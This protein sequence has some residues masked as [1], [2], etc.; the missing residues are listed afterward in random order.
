MIIL[1]SREIIPLVRNNNIIIIE[2][3][4]QMISG[5]LVTTR[6]RFRL[7]DDCLKRTASPSPESWSDYS[8]LPVTLILRYLARIS[9][10]YGI[11]LVKYQWSLYLLPA[12]YSNTFIHRLD[13]Q[14]NIFFQYFLSH[15]LP[16]ILNIW[17]HNAPEEVPHHQICK[18]S[19]WYR[20]LKFQDFTELSVSVLF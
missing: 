8:G 19:Q 9:K 5:I 3:T 1:D 18:R 2:L 16:C 7:F 15:G 4:S 14:L 6:S 17:I 12:Y 13:W 11:I 10:N 20:S